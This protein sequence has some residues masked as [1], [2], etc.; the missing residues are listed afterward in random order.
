MASCNSL[1]LIYITVFVWASKWYVIFFEKC[2]FPWQN[3]FCWKIK[4]FRENVFSVT[5]YFWW[6]INIF[7]ENVFFPWQIF[8]WKLQF[9]EEK[10]ICDKFFFFTNFSA[11]AIGGAP[12]IT[13]CWI[14]SHLN[15]TAV[16]TQRS[17]LWF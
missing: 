8:F 1:G 3:I 15:R 5:K 13:P 2:F 14:F 17:M 6:K 11:P 7:L 12:A 16:H 4:F 9:F 10:K